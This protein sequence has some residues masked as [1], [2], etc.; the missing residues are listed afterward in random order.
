MWAG[1]GQAKLS[2]T[3]GLRGEEAVTYC[4]GT[5]QPPLTGPQALQQDGLFPSVPPRNDLP[6]AARNFAPLTTRWTRWPQ[7]QESAYHQSF[8]F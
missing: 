5:Q 8:C 2:L 1:T 6:L 3:P 4:P 7:H